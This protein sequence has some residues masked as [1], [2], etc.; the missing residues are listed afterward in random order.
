[1]VI[2]S[3]YFEKFLEK[4]YIDIQINLEQVFI[5]TFYFFFE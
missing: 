1:M 5:I 4:Y 3:I 2:E